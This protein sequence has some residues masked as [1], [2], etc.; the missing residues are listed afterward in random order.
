M[1]LS[2]NNIQAIE[3]MLNL[4]TVV[5]VH[6]TVEGILITARPK[7]TQDFNLPYPMLLSDEEEC[8]VSVTAKAPS[9][10][11]P[12]EIMQ[13][14]VPRDYWLYGLRGFVKKQ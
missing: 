6:T 9:S 4:N 7:D 5:E 11:Y 10:E 2:P 14:M 8:R 13:V 12:V 1:K 3:A